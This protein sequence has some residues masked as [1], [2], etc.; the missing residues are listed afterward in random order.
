MLDYHVHSDFSIDCDTPMDVSCR[1]AVAAG[2]TE[3]AFTDHLDHET[4]DPGFGYYRP[5]EYLRS[6]EAV[7]Q[8]F[9]GQLTVLA[10]VE[11]DFNERIAPAVERFITRYGAGYDVIIGSVHYT[12]SGE[13]IFPAHFRARSLD[14]VFVPY[15]RQVRL[16]VDTGWFDTIGHL[17]LPKRYAPAAT[18]GT[19]DPL[20]YRTYLEPIFAAL[21]ERGMSFE[22]NTS[23]LRQT[24]RTSMPGPAVVRWYVEAGGT[25]I[26]TG[27]DSHVAE[28]IGSGLARSLAMLQVCGIATVSAF[29]SRKRRQVPIADL[30]GGDGVRTRAAVAS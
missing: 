19:Y 18:H 17:D 5:E 30:L 10:G 13:L 9:A 7:R 20:L 16:A 21:I 11:I 4:A 27:S 23:G 1:A 28:T 3:I 29:R 22:I 2:V 25:L 12:T 26:T 15:L 24:P 14:D 6:I 8:E